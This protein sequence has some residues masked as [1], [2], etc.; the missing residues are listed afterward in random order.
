L[1][2]YLPL[3]EPLHSSD[4]IKLRRKSL[5][6]NY[7]GV[8]RLLTLNVPDKEAYDKVSF[9]ERSAAYFHRCALVA[10]LLDENASREKE[11]SLRKKGQH[12]EADRLSRA[13][14]KW[15]QVFLNTQKIPGYRE[16]EQSWIKAW[17]IFWSCR[18]YRRVVSPGKQVAEMKRQFFV[19][20]CES[21][22]INALK[23]NAEIVRDSAERGDLGFFLDIA[24]AVSRS[25][26]RKKRSGDVKKSWMWNILSRWLHGCLWLMSTD[27]GSIALGELTGVRMTEANYTKIVQRLGL[28]S[29]RVAH[30]KPVINGYSP[31]TRR[32]LFAPGWT[33]LD[34]DMSK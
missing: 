26:R 5:C 8:A 24:K 23:Y 10:M 22:A 3:R 33:H 21:D 31:K 28:V 18:G 13:R 29:W 34:S 11:I 17:S 20:Q 1:F 27:R 12:Q 2:L 7:H 9:G 15:Y 19:V 25:K 4:A 14:P 32:F 30:K 6:V 16:A